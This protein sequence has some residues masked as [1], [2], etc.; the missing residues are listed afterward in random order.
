MPL[1]FVLVPRS[2]FELIMLFLICVFGKS[3]IDIEK[4]YSLLSVDNFVIVWLCWECVPTLIILAVSLEPV[5]CRVLPP[6]VKD[7]LIFSPICVPF[8]SFSFL[9]VLTEAQH[10]M[11]AAS[12]DISRLALK[13]MLPGFPQN[14]G[15]QLPHAAIICWA[16]F[17]LFLLSL[18]P[19]SARDV[20]PCQ[21]LPLCPLR[22]FVISVPESN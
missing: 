20:G 8:V 12:T 5:K 4:N 1:Y 16:M 18:G 7:T 3:I 17:L 6:A 14:V 11:G 15:V 22:W 9:M 10:H 19:L 13:E 21:R 2:I